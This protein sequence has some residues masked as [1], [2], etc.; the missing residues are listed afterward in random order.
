[1]DEFSRGTQLLCS[2]D[3]YGRNI[4]NSTKEE[5]TRRQLIL[6]ETIGNQKQ[7]CAGVREPYADQPER[8]YVGGDNVTSPRLHPMALSPCPETRIGILPGDTFMTTK[9]DSVLIRK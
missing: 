2:I 1:M 4:K 8:G 7:Q 3:R 9:G 6:G 5:S